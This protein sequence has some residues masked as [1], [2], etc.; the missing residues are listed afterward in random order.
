MEIFLLF[1]STI[2]F[3]DINDFFFF[4]KILSSSLKF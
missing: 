4:L 3:S 2:I 1:V